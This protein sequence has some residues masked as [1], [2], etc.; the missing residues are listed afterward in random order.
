MKA[1]ATVLT[2]V[3]VLFTVGLVQAGPPGELGVT[4]EGAWM[5]RFIWRGFDWFYQND[6]AFL[7]GTNVDFW[8]TG[9]GANI[10]WI[11]ATHSGH[12]NTELIVYNP[13][14]GSSG[15]QGEPWQMNYRFGWRY[16][17]AP[18][19]PLRHCCHP[20]DVDWQVAYGHFSWPNVCSYGVVPWY[21]CAAMWPDEGGRHWDGCDRSYFRQ[22]GGFFHTFGL[23]KDWTV[24]GFLPKT[25]EQVIHTSFAMTYN[26]GAGPTPDS[27]RNNADHDWS[28]CV[29]GAS[30]DIVLSESHSLLTFSPGIYYQN[31]WDDSVNPSNEIWFTLDLKYKF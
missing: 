7:L 11:P 13:Y 12:Q 9:F 31:S 16:Y 4:V 14:F 24:P 29:W 21:E 1:K 28:H 5:S 22:K 19:G 8:D 10:S 17:N 15:W 20:R 25:P 27:R 26:D 6:S 18:D 30:T 3:I 2:V 23:N